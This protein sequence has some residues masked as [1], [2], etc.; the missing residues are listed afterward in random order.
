LL[1]AMMPTPDDGEPVIIWSG[2]AIDVIGLGIVDRFD[3]LPD[4]H[5]TAITN[6]AVII[7]GDRHLSLLPPLNALLLNYPIPFSGLLEQLRSHQGKQVV[8]L[9]SGD[10]LFF[11][12]GDWLG[13]HLP[14]T[15]LVFH[16]NISSIQAAFA[17]LGMPWQEAT[18]ISLHG[19]PLNTLKARLRGHCVYALLTDAVNHPAAIATAL[20]DW[21]QDEA[22]CWVV[23]AL[24]GS[25]E[26]LQCLSAIELANADK[27]F[28][29]LNLLLVKTGKSST[30]EF[31]GI[32]DDDFA[33]DG[34]ISKREIRLMILSLLQPA[35]TET[36]WD[37]GAGCGGVA[38]EWAR[39]NRL[40]QVIAVENR[41]QRLNCLDINRQRFGVA[42]NLSIVAA[43][44]PAC[45]EDL[46]APDCVFVGGGGRDLADILEQV[47][48]RLKPG[49]RLVAAA[50]SEPSRATLQ[51]FALNIDS[52]LEWSQIA[53]SRPQELGGQLIMQPRLPVLLMKCIKSTDHE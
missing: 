49:G 26:R 27:R 18:V 12:V 32:P 35:S 40:G 37:I 6:A 31:P 1:H 52:G 46:P 47:W 16:P 53:V 45:L 15:A 21:G 50:V 41:Q 25:D 13:R 30:I 14:A 7:G 33:T 34:M 23:E 39:W 11:G 5:Q 20:C 29:P 17:R 51:Q 8:I 22:V 42:A 4:G 19:R 38:I 36:G 10:P 43:S 28:H 24:G 3:A 9:A 48:R 44:A 2:P